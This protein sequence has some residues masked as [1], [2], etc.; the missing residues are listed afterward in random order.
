MTQLLND[1]SHVVVEVT[2]NHYRSAGVLLDDV[3]GDLSDSDCPVLQVL[4]F[5][6]F[7]IAVENLDIFVA[8]LQLGPT[9]ESAECLH[10][11]ESRVSSR[12]IPASTTSSLHGLVRPESPKIEGG[13]QLGLVEADHLGSVILQEFIDTLLFRLRVQTSD[14]EGDQ[15]ELLP[16]R[17]HIGEVSTDVL[18]VSVGECVLPVFSATGSTP[19]LI[20]AFVLGLLALLWWWLG[21]LLFLLFG[22]LSYHR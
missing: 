16:L 4:L 18:F 19:T 7:E 11:L 20:L 12:S 21:Y 5:S 8:E 13:L 1:V 17:S 6:W 2:T 14:I 22:C 15:F 9:E 10:K 3:P